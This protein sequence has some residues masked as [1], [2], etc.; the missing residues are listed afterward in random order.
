MCT[1]NVQGLGDRL[2]PDTCGQQGE[3]VKNWQNLTGVLYGW[4]L[5]NKY[6]NKYYICN[7]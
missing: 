2:N 4:P 5:S 7:N 1:P 3:G 6:F